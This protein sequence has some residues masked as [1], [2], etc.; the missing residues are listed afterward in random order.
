MCDCIE[1]KTK[2]LVQSQE[3]N[4]PCRHVMVFLEFCRKIE[5]NWMWQCD[6]NDGELYVHRVYVLIYMDVNVNDEEIRKESAKQ[7]ITPNEK[8]KH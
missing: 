7:L 4:Y 8:K 6:A 2:Y 3:I 1:M 5:S